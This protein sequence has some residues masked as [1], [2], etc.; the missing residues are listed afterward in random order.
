[1]NRLFHRLS[2]RS[3]APRK[4]WYPIYPDPEQLEPERLAALHEETSKTLRKTLFAHL[5]FSFFCAFTLLGSP[6]RAP[7]VTGSARFR[8]GAP[9]A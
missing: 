8:T 1:M 6:D 7:N 5:I 2:D 4:W 3:K 9:P